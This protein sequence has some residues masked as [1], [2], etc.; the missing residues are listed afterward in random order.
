MLWSTGSPGLLPED[1]LED[2]LKGLEPDEITGP[3]GLLTQ[4]AGRVIET[5]LGGGADRASRPSAG[6]RGAGPER[7][8][9]RGRKRVQTDLGP[10][11]GQHAARS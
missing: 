4:L 9:R 3:G 11:R 10:V 6:R 7:S 5:A 8:Q 2:A 1:A